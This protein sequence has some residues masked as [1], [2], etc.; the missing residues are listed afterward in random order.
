M[1]H[2]Q[3][4][5]VRLS[6]L[7]RLSP[8]GLGCLALALTGC[9]AALNLD[10][11][12]LQ[13]EQATQ[14]TDF[15]QAMASNPHVTVLV[16]N[17]GVV[18]R[19]ENNGEHWQRQQ[20]PTD[21]SL[22]DLAVC[23]D[24]SFIALSFDNHIW[25]ADARAEGWQAHALPSTEQ[26]MTTRCAPDGSWWAAGAF[27]TLQN[28][29]DQ[30]LSWDELSLDEDAIFTT[31]QFINADQVVVSGE[32]GLRFTS[33]DGGQNWQSSHSLPDEFYPHASY[34][35][36]LD[37]GWVGGLNGF[38]WHTEDGG[39]TWTRQN[40]GTEAPIFGFIHGPQGLYAVGENA[41]VL[42]LRG[43]RWEALPTPDQPLYLR[44]GR[45]LPSQHLLAAGGRGLLLNI[46][47]PKALAASTD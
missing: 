37:T 25:H 46:D 5:S 7:S 23:P 11:V 13:S 34:Y 24:G 20:L 44:A 38:I 32:Y 39:A 43:Q 22:I 42:S 36:S 47:L 27:S 33:E 3:R 4:R 14:R 31:L 21:M 1:L 12:T 29:S 6:R 19:S 18:L 40:T 30:G 17:Q 16:G 9:E 41:T 10:A 2:A 35:S 45:L 15:Y 8:L 28:S 26:M